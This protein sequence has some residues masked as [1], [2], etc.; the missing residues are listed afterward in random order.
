MKR[1]LQRILFILAVFALIALAGRHDTS[2]AAGGIWKWDAKVQTY[3]YLVNGQPVKNRW[4]GDY[5]LKADGRM[6]KKE[7]IWDDQNQAYYYLKNSGIYARNSWQ[8]NY[9]LKGNGKMADGEWFWDPTYRAYYYAKAGGAYA[10]SQWVGNYYLKANGKM[11]AS[12]WV[13]DPQFQEYFY[14]S[15][16]G[17]YLSERWQGNYY[18]KP[19]GAMA[20][21]EVMSLYY[22]GAYHQVYFD[23]NGYGRDMTAMGGLS[24]EQISAVMKRAFELRLTE[25]KVNYPGTYASWNAFERHYKRYNG[26]RDRI[27]A[28]ANEDGGVQQ[29]HMKV[30]Y[31]TDDSGIFDLQL[32]FQPS[33]LL[34]GGYDRTY[35]SYKAYLRK[36][37]TANIYD[38]HIFSDAEKVRRIRNHIVANYTYDDDLVNEADANVSVHSPLALFTNSHGVCQAYALYFRDMAK[39]AGLDVRYIVGTGYADG[40]SFAHAWN[41]VR[42]G[43]RWYAYDPTWNDSLGDFVQYNL[44]G[45]K[46]IEADHVPEYG[47]E[48][49]SETDYQW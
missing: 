20:A 6:A 26:L 18:L 4:V 21:N 36:W 22:D 43:G 41:I 27:Q 47:H 38:K 30:N 42:V 7:W 39:I 48:V 40:T 45:R 34:P 10:M 13:F 15:A 32:T 16:E 8:G 44:V 25:V 17:S 5:F 24:D 11:A 9:Y 46:T 49:L 12:E 23:K 35:A 2:Q 1:Q 29:W 28:I 31:Y 19:G 14:F 37:V 33:Y 3:Y